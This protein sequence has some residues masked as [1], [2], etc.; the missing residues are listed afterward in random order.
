MNAM[1]DISSAFDHVVNSIIEPIEREANK[2][3]SR[4]QDTKTGKPTSGSVALCCCCSG[5]SGRGRGLVM[6]AR[7]RVC[8]RV[9]LS[10]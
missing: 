7:A 6:C 2:L 4:Y 8:V 9:R 3:A 1:K 5:D 10:V